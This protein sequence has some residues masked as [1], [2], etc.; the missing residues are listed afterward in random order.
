MVVPVSVS[1]VTSMVYALGHADETGTVM[2]TRRKK[3]ASL[4]DASEAAAPGFSA[5]SRRT[6]TRRA[7]GPAVAGGCPSASRTSPVMVIRAVAAVSQPLG[8]A[9]VIGSRDGALAVAV[10]VASAVAGA[11]VADP[12]DAAVGGFDGPVSVGPD[13]AQ[14]ACGEGPGARRAGQVEISSP[15]PATD[16]CSLTRSD[17]A[18]LVRTALRIGTSARHHRSAGGRPYRYVRGSRITPP[19]WTGR[20]S[21]PPP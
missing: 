15:E 1:S 3:P 8:G 4:T 17:P 10:L 16:D 2:P 13:V 18:H 11:S 9:G 6:A 12:V 20:T 7:A 5:W 14:P 21:T 19:L